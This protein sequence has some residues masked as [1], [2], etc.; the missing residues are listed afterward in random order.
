MRLVIALAVSA[1]CMASSGLAAD[2]NFTVPAPTTIAPLPAGSTPTPV[3]L[4]R[5]LVQMTQGDQYGVVRGG[6]LCE[7]SYA[8]HW[9]AA[10]DEP[11]STYAPIFVSE[12][13]AA[14]FRAEGDP[15][16]LFEE[17]SADI[18]VGVVIRNVRSNFCSRAPLFGT[19]RMVSG[20]L[21]FEADWQVYSTLR[22]QVVA[23]VPT[24]GGFV[25]EKGVPNGFSL[26]FTQAFAEHVRQLAASEAF[27]AAVTGPV[28]LNGPA[29][30]L[31]P[32]A[33]KAAPIAKRP[34]AASSE[35]VIAVFA[36]DGHGTGF[37]ISA[38]GYVLTN[39]HVVGGTK[40]VKVRWPDRTETLGEVV[41][42]DRRRD[43]ALIKVDAAGRKPL[44]L[45][46]GAA[47]LGEAVFAI[48]TPLDAKFQGTVTKGIVSS[49]RTY[50]GQTFIQSDV[51]INPGNSGGPLLDE[52]GAVLGLA[53]SG[54][55]IGDAP[56]GL[57]LFI[58]IA[59]A[60]DALALKPAS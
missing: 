19:E 21:M 18:S 49:N 20:K 59:D 53:V 11:V 42:S 45:R 52:D 43:V 1:S 38:D 13:S 33:F 24:Q 8:V 36:G 56:T 17:R 28:S 51:N 31:S 58:P 27:R 29:A 16:N 4:A 44:A 48:G 37:L 55:R 46:A 9:K 47:S 32:I 15:T 5:V 10:D 23:R 35:S 60:L 2:W 50:D 14:G 40:Y 22:Q 25:I 30:A 7:E 54:F 26:A 34:V 57:N 41:R 6:V 12:L 3:K 39:H